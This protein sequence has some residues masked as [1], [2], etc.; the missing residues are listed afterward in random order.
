MIELEVLKEHLGIEEAD[1]SQ[2]DFVTRL[3]AAAVA[4]VQNQTGW[5]FGEEDE[6]V[7]YLRGTGTSRLWLKQPP[8]DVSEVLKLTHAGDTGT[9]VVAE[10]DD[11][12]V[13]RGAQLIRKANLEWDKDYEYRV[14]FDRGYE[15]NAEPA[16]IR[17]LVIDLVAAKYGQR[18]K[19][20]MKSETYGGYS[21][22]FADADVQQVMGARDVIDFYRGV[23]LR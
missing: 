9:E 8:T 12:F 13:V 3:E 15:A 18:G 7:V 4:Y 14:T 19:E 20:G 5:F 10:D 21:Y 17:Q 23:V 11:G 1:E 6:A 22:T 16:D 2:D